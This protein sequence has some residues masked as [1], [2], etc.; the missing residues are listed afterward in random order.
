MCRFVT[1]QTGYLLSI[2]GVMHSVQTG[3][4]LSVGAMYSVQIFQTGYLGRVEKE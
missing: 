1:F 3:Y 2:V 4:L